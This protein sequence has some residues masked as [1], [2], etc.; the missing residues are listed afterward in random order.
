MLGVLFMVVC[1]KFGLY[2]FGLGGMHGLGRAACVV[3]IAQ[4]C[5]VVQWVLWWCESHYVRLETKIRPN[6][7]N[8]WMAQQP[9]LKHM[10]RALWLCPIPIPVHYPFGVWKETVALRSDDRVWADMAMKCYYEVE[11][12]VS[13][14]D[15]KKAYRQLAFKYHPGTCR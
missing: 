5:G 12:D 1:T 6:S 14:S 10:A 13:G 3:A 7:L 8:H 9:P 2:V 15:L 4:V 11:R